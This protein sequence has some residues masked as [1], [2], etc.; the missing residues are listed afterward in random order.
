MLNTESL[1]MGC[2]NDNAGEK[3]CPV[4]GYDAD[5]QNP[6]DCLPVKTVVGGRYTLGRVLSRNGEG[7]VYIAWDERTNTIVNIKEY[8][9]LGIAIRNAD[10]TVSALCDN[11]Y[12][13]NESLLEFLELNGI[14]MKNPMPALVAV[15]D[16]FEE[17]GTAFA[18]MQNIPGITLGD[19]LTRNGGTLKWEQA[20]ALLLPL[21]D[22]IS[23]MN[24]IGVIH[25]GISP[26]TIIVGRDG[27]LRI[28]N[29]AV[30]KLRVANE[31]LES[32][33]FEGFA[34]IEQYGVEG[35]VTD[36]YTD[37]YG[38]CATLFN[39]LLGSVPK[40]A[41]LRLENG[42]MSIPARFAEELP[43]HVLAALA[44]GLQVKPEDRTKDIETLKNEL[45]Y[46]EIEK[47]KKA[48]PK[49]A[50][51]KE[52]SK[53]KKSGSNAKYVVIS[54]GITALVF[55]GIAAILVFT[56]FRND[57]FG[58][59]SQVSSSKPIESAPVIEPIGSVDQNAA[60]TAKLY[61]VPDF[62]GKTY[63][64]I[65]ENE[66]NDKFKIV[67]DIAKQYSDKIAKG[68][69]CAQSVAKGS[70]VEKDTEIKLTISLG[71]AQFKIAD[72]VGKTEDEAKF[73]L[74]K[75]GFLYENIRVLEKYNEDKT[76]GVILEQTPAFGAT[77]TA[78]DKVEIYINTFQGDEPM[79]FYY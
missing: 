50:E 9:P 32:E 35:F 63:V 78:D 22:A 12:V 3:V 36:K 30:N 38:F 74:L 46:A 16:I 26:N 27:K 6:K 61:S 66:E 64:E 5:T 73:E 67:I 41:T 33:I 28:T 13:F 72:V 31:S 14:I 34:A 68:K 39:V 53:K 79:D 2:M 60:E 7:I 59:D 77:V 47:A 42:A 40:K 54:A 43:R 55:I 17:N 69:V 45:V 11:K 58:T 51:L 15:D 20:R 8:F 18:V 75:Q 19:F 71:P 23:A 4:C 21:I 48:E 62:T 70:Q 44:N 52:K 29:Y 49:K 76:P 37:V 65:I 1:C 24:E 25:K 57:I 10:N 56:V